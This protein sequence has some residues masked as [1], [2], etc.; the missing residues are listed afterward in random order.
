MPQLISKKD[1]YTL[2]EVAEDLCVELSVLEN[3][4]ARDFLG[5]CVRI[6]DASYELFHLKSDK[7]YSKEF[8]YKANPQALYRLNADKM[9]IIYS[10]ESVHSVVSVFIE[11][12]QWS[13]TTTF[14]DEIDVY[15]ALSVTKQELLISDYEK[16]RFK[17]SFGFQAEFEES[18]P[19]EIEPIETVVGKVE[20]RQ[21][22]IL[23]IIE[24]LG[25]SADSLPPRKKEFQGSGVKKEVRTML[26]ERMLLDS[27]VGIL[28]QPKKS[29]LRAWEI[30]LDKEIIKYKK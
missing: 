15:P 2:P 13:S 8:G 25:H 28:F 17:E 16:E 27:D 26:N 23:G 3:W 6:L 10:A 21:A 11:P 14:K 18:E 19:E 20:R 29:F 9:K 22:V 30:L 5:V 24:N 1:A 7:V 4:V 12:N